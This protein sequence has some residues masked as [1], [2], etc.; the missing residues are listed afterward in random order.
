M[1]EKVPNRRA[2]GEA[3][4]KALSPEER[5]QAASRA[6][7]ARWNKDLPKAEFEGVLNFGTLEFI[8]AIVEGKGGAP[9]LRLISQGEFMKSMGIYY[10]GYIAKQRRESEAPAVLPMFL[11]QSA[12]KPFIHKHLDPLQLETVNYVTQGGSIAKGIPADIIPNVC[13]IW[14][15]AKNAGVL[16]PKQSEIAEKAQIILDALHHIAII[17]LV[18][19]A[20]GYQAVRARFE[21]QAILD[22]FLRKSF[23]AWSKRIPDEFYKEIYRLRGWEWPGM[24][25]NRFQVC[26]KYT[27]D[28]IYKRLAPG[29]QEELERKNPKDER[30]K[31]AS[32]HHQWLTED[33]G[34]PALSAHMHAVLSLMRASQSWSQFKTLI[35]RAFPIK[36]TNIQFELNLQDVTA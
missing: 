36:G 25:I 28:L 4:A 33:I 34:H 11:A 30:G 2:G 13:K 24:Q 7:L 19:E 26:G 18:D 15:D 20:T 5:K 17:A 23:A 32:K 35:D 22:A 12:L 9:P 8:C 29:V 16:K 3:R 10:S 31:R 21:L 14:V 1:T 27:T 6:A